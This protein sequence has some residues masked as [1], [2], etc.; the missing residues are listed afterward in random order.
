MKEF[1]PMNEFKP[2]NEFKP[3]PVFRTLSL[4]QW[5]PRLG[6]AE[7]KNTIWI[8][9]SCKALLRKKISSNLLSWMLTVGHKGIY[10]FPCFWRETWQ[11]ENPKCFSYRLMLLIK[12]SAIGWTEYCA[13]AILDCCPTTLRLPSPLLV[14]SLTSYYTFCVSTT[15]KVIG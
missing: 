2:I 6:T 14:L 11:I 3:M 13:N 10:S 9:I 8:R 5:T 4:N 15:A 1:K 7:L 12:T